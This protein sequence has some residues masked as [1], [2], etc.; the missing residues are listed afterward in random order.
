MGSAP[1][2]APGKSFPHLRQILGGPKMG[3]GACLVTKPGGAWAVLHGLKQ[4]GD[5]KG[6]WWSPRNHC[7]R[8]TGLGP[9][10]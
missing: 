3:E 5:R 6:S 10:L 4:A 8:V 2:S 9:A 1:A 7:S